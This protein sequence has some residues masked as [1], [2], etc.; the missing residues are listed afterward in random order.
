M[1]T[2]KL[3][4]SY[5]DGR[6]EDREFGRGRYRLGRDTG[7]VVLGD[8]NTSA[9][10]AELDVEPPLA[11]LT[12]AGSTNGTF[13]AAGTRLSAPYVMRPGEPLRLGSTQ[14]TLLAAQ[15]A[16]GGT[17]VMGQVP[18][19][20]VAPGPTGYG[21]PPGASA[22]QYGAPP[23]AAAPQYGSP[24]GYGAPPADQGAPPPAGYGAPPA[25]GYGAPPAGYGAPPAGYGAPPPPG[26]GAAPI[27][28]WQGAPAAGVSPAAPYGI[29][30]VSGLP[31]SDKS[32]LV[33]GLLQLFF[34]SFAVGRF[35][36]GYT[37][38]AIVQIAV[39]FIVGA[40]GAAFTCGASLFVI[41]WPA[42][43]GILMLIGKVPDAQGR[44]LRP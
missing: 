3:R 16:K 12:D 24:P 44:P 43:D 4:I 21:P 1:S 23:G 13:D 15:P 30:P 11:R 19:I 6:T 27:A 8:P 25:A 28:P 17:Q 29:D 36:L 34:G 41:L 2:V 14:I 22:P 39:V 37:T 33:A 42:I 32:K 5:T 35:Y 10:H 40:G 38:I 18:E 26:Y 7:D 20:G 31:F 9:V